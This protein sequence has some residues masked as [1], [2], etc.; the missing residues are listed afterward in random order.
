MIFGQFSRTRISTRAA[1]DLRSSLA[2]STSK[3]L[4]SLLRRRFTELVIFDLL[5]FM[6]VRLQI[7]GAMGACTPILVECKPLCERFGAKM[8]QPRRRLAAPCCQVAAPC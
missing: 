6:F 3:P 8:P 1:I 2:A 4:T 7:I 5:Y